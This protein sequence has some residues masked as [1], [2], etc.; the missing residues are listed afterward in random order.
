MN[1]LGNI[2]HEELILIYQKHKYFLSTSEFE[3]NPKTILEA[4][5]NGCIVFAKNNENI[6]EIIRDNE[7][8]F[9]FSN[10][11]ELIV[12]FE[13][14]YENEDSQL[15]NKDNYSE[16]LKKNNIDLISEKMFKDYKDLI[17]FK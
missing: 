11:D 15:K 4:L 9:L 14:E 2:N 13:K 5:A 17:D 12:A 7:N 16:Y 6:A 1:F 10:I 8:G 3:G